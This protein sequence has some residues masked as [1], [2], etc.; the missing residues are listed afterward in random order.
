ML[1]LSVKLLKVLEVSDV[2]FDATT[3]QDRSSPSLRGKTTSKDICLRTASCRLTR[4]ALSK[5]PC[6]QH[7]LVQVR[8]EL[9]TGPIR[10]S[11]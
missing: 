9:Q 5:S 3:A 1:N 10:I 11:T 4:T 6:T 2:T 8:F 7:S